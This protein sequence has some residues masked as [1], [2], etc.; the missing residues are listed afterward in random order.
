MVLRGCFIVPDD[1][2]K[3]G[4][5]NMIFSNRHCRNTFVFLLLLIVLAV[6]QTVSVSAAD[7]PQQ[8]YAA[9]VC[10][11]SE[12]SI[13]AMSGGY[14]NP[15][16]YQMSEDKHE[17][18]SKRSSTDKAYAN[19]GFSRIDA[20]ALSRYIDVEKISEKEFYNLNF[21]MKI[22]AVAMT[23]SGDLLLRTTDNSYGIIK[24]SDE[25]I[26]AMELT[27]VVEKGISQRMA[28]NEKSSE[29]SAFSTFILI[30]VIVSF[31]IFIAWFCSMSKRTCEPDKITV[32]AK[33]KAKNGDASPVKK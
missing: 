29:P 21:N 28:A 2:M 4:S 30:M 6:P 16:I 18:S 20:A 13:S 23:T 7:Q 26:Q 1:S 5:A 11:S 33:E 12:A 8:N 10:G 25:Y 15:L 14:I 22:A 19:L 31:I 17:S 9:D 27:G 24:I 3:G 32:G